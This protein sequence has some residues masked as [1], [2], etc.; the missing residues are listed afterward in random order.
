MGSYNPGLIMPMQNQNSNLFSS[1][2]LS[3]AYPQVRSVPQHPSSSASS[4]PNSHISTSPPLEHLSVQ[5]HYPNQMLQVAPVIQNQI[6]LLAKVGLAQSSLLMNKTFSEKKRS[7]LLE[8]FRFVKL[9]WYL[10]YLQVCHFFRNNLL[11]GLSLSDLVGHVMEFAED[12]H[13]SRFIQQKLET[14]SKQE[15]ENIFKVG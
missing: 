8:D 10:N 2:L 6:P 14:A 5:Q 11:P 4:S 15:K 13:G 1:T 7:S 3:N 12:Q 9:N